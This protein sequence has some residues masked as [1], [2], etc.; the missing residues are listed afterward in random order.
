MTRALDSGQVTRMFCTLQLLTPH[1]LSLWCCVG[2]FLEYECSKISYHCVTELETIDFPGEPLS[3]PCPKQKRVRQDWRGGILQ[4]KPR[5]GGKWGLPPGWCLLWLCGRLS[6]AQTSGAPTSG[7]HD[8]RLCPQ[9]CCVVAAPPF[10]KTVPQL[11]VDLS[12]PAL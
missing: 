10:W 2:W 4:T 9:V 5:K 8:R 7:K 12:C 1:A 6:P 11:P 3:P